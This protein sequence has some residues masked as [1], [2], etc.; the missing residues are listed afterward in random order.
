MLVTVGNQAQ[1]GLSQEP[2]DNAYYL[3]GPR[4]DLHQLLRRLPV[5][6]EVVIPS[7]QVIIY[8]SGIG[9]AG[10]GDAGYIV[11]RTHR[12]PPV[13]SNRFHHSCV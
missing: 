12:F 5:D 11:I 6:L 8:A 9:T 7:Q 10:I 1:H 4:S 3:S 2:A 13:T